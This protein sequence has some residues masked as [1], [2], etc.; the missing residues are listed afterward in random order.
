MFK[1]GKFFRFRP[2]LCTRIFSSNAL[3][4][5][6]ICCFLVSCFAVFGR[7]D[8]DATG[9]VSEKDI[10]PGTII[11]PAIN[12]MTVYPHPCTPD[13]AEPEK[14]IA[15]GIAAS[16]SNS[17]ISTQIGNYLLDYTFNDDIDGSPPAGWTINNSGG[18]VTVE[19]VPSSS[20]KSMK[21]YKATPNSGYSAGYKTYSA[22]SSGIVTYD[23][24]VMTPEIY[25]DKYIMA[26][27]FEEDKI[28]ATIAFSNGYIKAGSTNVQQFVANQW[29]HI[30]AD[31][32]I[33]SKTYTLYVDG[34]NRG[35]YNFQDS[36]VTN[37][38][39]VLFT[40]SPGCYGTFYISDIKISKKIVTNRYSIGLAYFTRWNPVFASM[41]PTAKLYGRINDWFG[42]VRDHITQAGP[43]GNGPIADR[44]PLLGWYNDLNQSTIDQHILQAASRGID[45]FM[46]YY[47]WKEG[48]GGERAGQNIYNYLNS[49]YKDLIKFSLMFCSDSPWPSS[50]W[51]NYIIPR[52]VSFMQ[53]PQYKRTPD[54]RPILCIFG[55]L[56]SHFNNSESQ[57]KA[58]LDRLRT[59]AQNA[60][61]P[62]PLILSPGI[63]DE[64][65]WIRQGF[66]G[67][68]PLNLAGIGLF[69][70]EYTPED[71]SV[72]PDA[73]VDYVNQHYEDYLFIPGQAAAFDSRGWAGV[74]SSAQESERYVYTEPNPDKFRVHLN[75]V[76]DYLDT[77]PESMNIAIFY[78]WN[79]L[80]EGGTIEPTTLYG[81]GYLNALQE[82]FELDNS[83]YKNR[84][85]A[86]GLVDLDP[87]LRLEVIPEHPIATVNQLLKV[88]IKVT[89]KNPVQI[90]SGNVSIS[91]V[92]CEIVSST[93]TNISGLAPG[94]RKDVEYTIRVLN[95]PYWQKQQITV[96]ANYNVSGQQK[97]ISSSSF[98]VRVPEVNGVIEPVFKPVTAG[99]SFDITVR[100]RNYT[101]QSRQAT[102]QITVPPGWSI[103]GPE[104]GTV[105]LDGY[106][107]GPEWNR[108]RKTIH[109]IRIPSNADEGIYTINLYTDSSGVQTQSSVNIRV[110]NAIYNS[111]FEQDEDSD[112]VADVWSVAGDPVLSLSNDRVDGN[113]SQKIQA[114]GII[115]GIYQEWTQIEPGRNYIAEA[116]IKV[117]SGALRFCNVE[118]TSDLEWLGENAQV[119]AYLSGWQKYTL[120]ITPLPNSGNIGLRFDSLA[121]G[122]TVA[123]VDKVV[124][125]PESKIAKAW[126][127][128][129]A[130]ALEGWAGN[131]HISG[132]TANG[133]SLAGNIAGIDPA[134]TSDDNLG[135][136]ITSNKLIIIRMKNNTSSKWGQI[137]FTTTTDT[138]WNE[139]KHIDFPIIPNDSGYTEYIIDMSQ[140]PSKWT[141]TLKQL[142]IDPCIGVTSGSFSIDYVVIAKK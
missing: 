12:D 127:F 112:G 136:D 24:W 15:T 40:I 41:H 128:N 31:F 85:V 33:S 46:F 18:P 36:S 98:I 76:K 139:D 102:Y 64:Q 93:D 65:S 45:F 78:A 107:Q 26:R 101:F 125:K 88:K 39:E 50:D 132:L 81:Y 52:I 111:S 120:N 57:V 1:C 34:V 2:S 95:G 91:T 121:G 13:S 141:G 59:A 104:N 67:M 28:A 62:E 142:R 3:S 23:T 49:D 105:T 25:S 108:T 123:Y 27:N 109:S 84:V 130:G 58:A 29:Y 80:G 89:N 100:I 134:L 110:S 7:A 56:L 83:N 99:D 115:K 44:E 75:N 117:E 17:I 19:P 35:V 96:T 106:S 137:Y 77:H 133:S 20:E 70:N 97:N 10:T 74:S 32:D 61:L 16:N 55:E 138:A 66:D 126:E 30:V 11:E 122:S 103:I 60:G 129:T 114:N 90:Y 54:G 42:G 9:Y 131:Q 38:G 47:Y 135:C 71:Y 14:M 113:K 79:E 73:W 63:G 124:L 21:L 69:D 82:V 72:Y 68:A 140:L 119:I 53:D 8:V 94:A 87:D 22:Q 92:G 5:L 6:L 51:D 86:D 48:G 37:L 116:W 43:W 118:A 4:T